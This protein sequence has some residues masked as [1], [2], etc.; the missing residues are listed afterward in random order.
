[1][2]LPTYF[3]IL[4]S[5]I[6]PNAANVKVAKKA[7]EKLRSILEKDEDISDANPDTYLTGSYARDTAISD[8]KD[9]DIIL[10]INLDHLKVEPNVVVTWLQGV[11]Q[12]HYPNVIR[13]G[14]SVG[15]TTDNDF[16]LDVVPS[17]PISHR[18]GPIWIPDREIKNWVA[19][20]PKGQIAFGIEKNSATGGYYKPLVKILKFWRDRLKNTDAKVKSYI[21]ESMVA[22][23]SLGEPSS[24]G[25]AVASLF[26]FI[27]QKYYPYL[28]TKSMP[29]IYDPGY[30]SVNVAKRWTFQEFSVFLGAISEADK[31]AIA[32]LASTDESESAKLWQRLFGL[33][34][35][36]E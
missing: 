3:D 21:L 4:L 13:Q 24:Y 18:D 19:S 9:V 11:L 17:V 33:E 10:L 6:E 30:P 23:S 15:V 7:H 16:C 36:K 34:F 22:D 1:M 29:I 26:K 25:K 2:E 31:I 28:I 35:T 8:I 5:N 27:Y 20:H 14:R 32:A 12:K